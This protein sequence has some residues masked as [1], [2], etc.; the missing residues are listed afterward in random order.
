MKNLDYVCN[1]KSE[2]T[3]VCNAVKGHC[4]RAMNIVHDHA[5]GRFDQLI[6]EHWS[7]NP[8]IAE[9]SMLSGKHERLRLSIRTVDLVLGALFVI[10]SYQVFY[11]PKE[12][13]FGQIENADFLDIADFF[14]QLL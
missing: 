13:S 3:N 6:S 14:L 1:G 9:I 5:S 11:V 8:S 2:T 4:P 10:V 12:N 7:I